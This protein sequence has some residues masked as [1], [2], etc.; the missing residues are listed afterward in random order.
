MK[1]IKPRVCWTAEVPEKITSVIAHKASHKKFW[2]MYF[3][4]STAVMIQSPSLS[5]Q[6]WADIGSPGN[7]KI[8][9]P[10]LHPSARG[11]GEDGPQSESPLTTL[12]TWCDY[13]MLQEDQAISLVRRGPE[14]EDRQ[15]VGDHLGREGNMCP[16]RKF[17]GNNLNTFL[18]CCVLE[19]PFLCV[20]A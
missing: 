10:V 6:P 13:E 5:L 16:V 3:I 1:Y 14:T 15:W 11:G 8:H 20:F 12:P 17:I 18:T 7:Q 2:H 9:E 19:A 4:K